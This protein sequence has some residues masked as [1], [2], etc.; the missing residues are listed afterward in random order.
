[1]TSTNQYDAVTQQNR[2]NHEAEK[3]NMRYKTRSTN[4]AKDGEKTSATDC[5]ASAKVPLCVRESD[6]GKLI[7][8]GGRNRGGKEG[9]DREQSSTT[10]PLDHDPLLSNDLVLLKKGLQRIGIKVF[11]FRNH[12]DH[13]SKVGKQVALVPI[14]QHGRHAG[15]VKLDLVVVNFDEADRGMLGHQWPHGLLDQCTN[16]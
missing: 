4:E 2:R 16:F 3:N 14:C 13:S 5:K 8:R 1:M 12:V 15:T 11:I 9:V 6:D 10:A 7:S